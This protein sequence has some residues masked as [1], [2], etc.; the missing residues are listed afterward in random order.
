MRWKFDE[1][2]FGVST[3]YTP[4]PGYECNN[5]SCCVT[6]CRAAA[7]RN[8]AGTKHSLSEA[9]DSSVRSTAEA[10]VSHKFKKS[11]RVHGVVQLI[12]AETCT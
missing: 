2:W 12:F 10:G 3:E 11:S 6:T 7:A 9:K 1:V 5:T 8:E 4:S